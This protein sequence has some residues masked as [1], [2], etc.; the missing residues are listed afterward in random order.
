MFGD[1][2]GRLH[3]LDGKTGKELPGFPVFTKRTVVTAK[4]KRINP[5]P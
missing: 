2:D 3:A 4:H 5:G 1:S